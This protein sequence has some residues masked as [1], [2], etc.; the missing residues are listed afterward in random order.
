MADY[1]RGREIYGE[2]AQN[3]DQTEAHQVQAHNADGEQ[4]GGQGAEIGADSDENRMYEAVQ[5]R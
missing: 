3:A 1:E 5:S 4:V 2:Q